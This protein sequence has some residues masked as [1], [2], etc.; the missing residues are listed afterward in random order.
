MPR[1]GGVDRWITSTTPRTRGSK[2]NREGAIID[3]ADRLSAVDAACIGSTGVGNV[4]RPVIGKPRG[5]AHVDLHLIHRVAPSAGAVTGKAADRHPWD[6][7]DPAAKRHLVAIGVGAATGTRQRQRESIG[8]QGGRCHGLGRRGGRE[9]AGKRYRLPGGI[10]CAVRH[11]HRHGVRTTERHAADRL[12]GSGR[13]NAAGTR[14][15]GHRIAIGITGHTGNRYRHGGAADR[16]IAA[17]ALRRLGSRRIVPQGAGN[18]GI[19]DRFVLA[20]TA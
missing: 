6:G 17:D 13:R 2:V 1:Q 16:G 14:T 12:R 15:D 3:T 18:A 7:R 4:D 5:A 19:E 11:G 10:N 8:R 20:R 9:G